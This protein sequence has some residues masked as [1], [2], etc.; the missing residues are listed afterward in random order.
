MNIPLGEVPLVSLHA[1]IG[2]LFLLFLCS[3][4]YDRYTLS[5][6]RY[7]IDV[8]CLV[9]LVTT[10]WN[11][12]RNMWSARDAS[13]ISIVTISLVMVYLFTDTSYNSRGYF[14]YSVGFIIRYG[15]FQLCLFLITS[16]SLQ[17]QE[18]GT[19]STRSGA[20]RN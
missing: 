18:K 7:I 9:V 14:F 20:W 4:S 12:H 1:V 16:N 5:T 6:W 3:S 15:Y 19:A 8:E 10:G 2:G 13:S 17:G 11:V